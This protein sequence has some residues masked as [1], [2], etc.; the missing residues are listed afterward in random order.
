M[1]IQDTILAVLSDMH[2]GGSTALFPAAGYQ[3]NTNEGNLISPNKIQQEINKTMMRYSG[4][5]AAARKGKRLVIVM[6]GDAIEGLHHNTIQ[7]S[8]LAEKEQAQAHCN[9]MRAFM[10]RVGWNKKHGDELYYV[11]GTECH[12]KDSENQIGEELGA[13]RASSGAYV[14][15][16]LLLNINGIYSL[17][18]HHGRGRGYGMS[19]GQSLRNLV[20]DSLHER[21]KDGLPLFD[22][23]WSGHTH[24]HTYS[25]YEYR[26]PGG[27][28]K[29][30]HG[31]ICPSWQSKTRYA[32]AKV[33]FA[34]NSIG[35]TYVRITADGK[36]I[37]PPVFVVQVTGE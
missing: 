2:T 30:A 20:R 29:I 8:I 9:I 31:I 18:A 25:S 4:E 33:P 27:N 23:L 15:E 1:K 36:F 24:G 37:A 16:T 34:V 3:S 11:R 12:V 14:H 7:L 28:F 19:E 21:K 26:V 5:V 17:F 10:Q 35:G 13:V 32:Y 22:V 6:L